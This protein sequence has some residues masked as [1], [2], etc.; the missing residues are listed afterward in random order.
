MG[1]KR[2][3]VDPFTRVALFFTGILLLFLGFIIL[4]TGLAEPSNVK[5]GGLVLI[6]PLPFI[7]Y[8]D[9]FT[10]IFLLLFALIPLILI[11]FMLSAVTRALRSSGK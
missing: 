1:D 6:G 5:A 2:I 10:P 11:F 4:L 9:E 7:F 8:S 3:T